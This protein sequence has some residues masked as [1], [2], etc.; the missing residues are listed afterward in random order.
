MQIC[1]YPYPTSYN[2]G[3]E[4]IKVSTLLILNRTIYRDQI[5]AL[6]IYSKNTNDNEN[7]QIQNI[8]EIVLG[9][10]GPSVQRFS[11]EWFL[12]QL[13]KLHLIHQNTNSILEKMCII[14]MQNIAAENNLFISIGGDNYCYGK[15]VWFYS[16]NKYLKSVGKVTVLW[17]CSIEPANIDDEMIADLNRYNLITVREH[18]T[19]KNLV[20][21]GL[22]NTVW[23]PDPAFILPA[24]SDVSQDSFIPENTIGI[25]LSTLV[26]DYERRKGITYKSFIRL[27]QHIIQ[28]TDLQIALIPHVVIRTADDRTVLHKIYLQFKKTGRVIEIGDHNCKVQKGIIAKCRMFIGARTHAIIAAY[29]S[30][31]PTLAVGYSVKAIGIAEDIFGMSDHYVI[32]V[33][34]ITYETD[35]IQAFEWINGNE[36]NI[37][38]HLEKVMPAYIGKAWL[39]GEEIKRITDNYAN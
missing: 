14:S 6:S 35:L 23:C 22:T 30:C 39:A 37:R 1:L 4:A 25:N 24:C 34:N 29:S 8:C 9:F 10:T 16:V 19:Q 13:S 28:T 11:K 36:Q 20:S 12:L 7:Q 27:I 18:I 2:R 15:P 32:P 31:V 17:G 26:M 38:E 5:T 3:C 21:A 33:Q